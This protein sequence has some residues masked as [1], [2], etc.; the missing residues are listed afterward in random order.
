M[1]QAQLKVLGTAA[2]KAMWAAGKRHCA[3]V[4]MKLR[5][6]KSAVNAKQKAILRTKITNL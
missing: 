4:H 3:L 5:R 2:Q 6:L 1:R